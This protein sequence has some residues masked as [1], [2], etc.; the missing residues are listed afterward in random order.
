[1]RNS[2]IVSA[3]FIDDRLPYCSKCVRSSSTADRRVSGLHRLG[4]E[5]GS[6]VEAVSQAFERGTNLVLVLR[7][8]VGL[9]HDHRAVKVDDGAHPVPGFS[10]RVRR[11]LRLLLS[12]S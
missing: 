12:P 5:T 10:D 2:V 9:L 6:H 1:L 8:A 7:G 4:R 3:R 11:L